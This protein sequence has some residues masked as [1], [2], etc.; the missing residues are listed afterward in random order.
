M[1]QF[2]FVEIF[3]FEKPTT[4]I[5]ILDFVIFCKH[6]SQ[7][8]ANIGIFCAC[9]FLFAYAVTAV[10]SYASLSLYL[11]IVY[12]KIRLSISFAHQNHIY[13]Y[14]SEAISLENPRIYMYVK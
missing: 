5:Q 12:Q 1:F 9:L 3:F 11:L 2:E 7:W 6:N 8:C 4:L 10:Y 13:M 14:K